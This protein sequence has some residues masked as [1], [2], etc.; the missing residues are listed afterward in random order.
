ME[1]EFPLRG[2]EAQSVPVTTLC[3]MFDTQ[4]RPHPIRWRCAT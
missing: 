2:A 1:H 4:L 3:A